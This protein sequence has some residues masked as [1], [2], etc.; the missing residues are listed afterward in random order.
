MG[1]VGLIHGPDTGH[2]SEYGGRDDEEVAPRE[3]D[4]AVLKN[5]VLYLEG[6]CSPEPLQCPSVNLRKPKAALCQT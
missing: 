4:A 3:H 2:Q 6:V 5:R 1:V